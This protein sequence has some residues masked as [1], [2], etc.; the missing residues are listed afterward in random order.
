[1]LKCPN[2]GRKAEITKYWSCR[3]CGYPLVSRAFAREK[4]KR[5][6]EEA[7]RLR[8]EEAKV[9][10]EEARAKRIEEAARILNE[11]KRKTG[12]FSGEVEEK[13]RVEAEQ[14][15]KG[16]VQQIE[17]EAAEKQATTTCKEE[18][19]AERQVAKLAPPQVKSFEQPSRY[20]GITDEIQATDKIRVFIVDRDLISARGLDTC[21]SQNHR[22]QVIGRSDYYTEE[23]IL[24]IEEL[25]TDVVLVDIDLPSL[26]GLDLTRR[27]IERMHSISV[28][29]LTPY[30][31]DTHVFKALK[32]G[33]AAYLSKHT[34]AEDLAR[35]IVGVYNGECIINTLLIR[36]N[37][38]QQVLNEL[39]S[40]AQV[41]DDVTTSLSPQEMEMLSYF[42]NGYSRKQ[43][44]HAMAMTDEAIRDTLAQIASKLTA[45]ERQRKANSAS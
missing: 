2:C 26:S 11:S 25:A 6:A 44:A 12:R 33:A 18:D 1:M 22:I 5:D 38:A 17:K 9:R 41:M 23:T 16:I 21:L 13:I 3:W 39:H 45:N 29:L 4:A 20:S 8:R 10:K 43:V 31:D 36:P 40:A 14:I 7:K 35:V 37:V 15:I 42:A 19:A 27:I 32:S 34:P 30:E 24:T 28:I